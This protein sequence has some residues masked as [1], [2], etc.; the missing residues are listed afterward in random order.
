MK[1]FST[2]FLS[3]VGIVGGIALFQLGSNVNPFQDRILVGENMYG[4][5]NTINC[6]KG[7]MSVD[8]NGVLEGLIPEGFY[9]PEEFAKEY[10]RLN[11]EWQQSNDLDNSIVD[12]DRLNSVT[13][14][15]MENMMIGEIQ[16][17][18]S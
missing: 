10:T 2:A 15:F 5:T 13:S 17:A 14:R 7:T 8:M 12:F 18:C 16:K 9:T 11:Q 1:F 3:A 4:G 6:T